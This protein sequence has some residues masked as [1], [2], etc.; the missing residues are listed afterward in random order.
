[1]NIKYSSRQKMTIL[2][3]YI[4]EYFYFMFKRIV[5]RYLFKCFVKNIYI[6]IFANKIN[7][8]IRLV[9]VEIFL[10]KLIIIQ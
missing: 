8:T 6:Y 10:F 5:C 1:M 9:S 7:K 3:R 4:I 2:S